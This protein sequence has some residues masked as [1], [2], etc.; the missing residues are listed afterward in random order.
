[1]AGMA[2]GGAS[3]FVLIR[4]DGVARP[5]VAAVLGRRWPESIVV[6]VGAAEPSWTMA[7]GDAAKLAR[8][9]RGVEPLRVLVRSARSVDARARHHTA[10]PGGQVPIDPMPIAF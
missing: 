9:R 6:E 4:H 10:T 8:A 5:G 7:T 3:A 2:T 1:M